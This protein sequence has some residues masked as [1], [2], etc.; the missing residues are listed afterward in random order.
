MLLDISPN[1]F[2][3]QVQYI[4]I[5]SWRCLQILQCFGMSFASLRGS[6]KKKRK[7]HCELDPEVKQLRFPKNY[8]GRYQ[9][10]LYDVC[11]P[12]LRNYMPWAT[13]G[14]LVAT[15][16]VP[17]LAVTS[18]QCEGTHE[19]LAKYPHWWWFPF[20]LWVFL[21]VLLAPR[22]PRLSCFPIYI[23]IFI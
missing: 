5:L 10:G 16:L 2:G 13:L 22:R 4:A 6:S 14:H 12:P 11:G 7:K 18:S 15:I 20:F 21:M 3:T 1:Y 17:L 19:I 9:P 23:Y 8:E